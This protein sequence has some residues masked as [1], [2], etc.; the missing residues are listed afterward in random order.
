[1]KLE[2]EQEYNDNG[3]TGM[4][5]AYHS[6]KQALLDSGYNREKFLIE[7]YNHLLSSNRTSEDELLDYLTFA[8]SE[9]SESLNLCYA[10]AAWFQSKERFD[11]AKKWY[12][13][14]IQINP[15]HHYAKM[16]L[17]LLRLEGQIIELPR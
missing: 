4:T 6:K 7:F 11:D 12:E 1:L 2:L 14:C 17:G 10:L 8:V 5:K 16:K 13:R 15:A 9:C 3:L